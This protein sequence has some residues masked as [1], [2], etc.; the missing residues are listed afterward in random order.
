M[1][2]LT[3]KLFDRSISFTLGE[4]A[5]EFTAG[6]MPENRIYLPYRGVSRHHFTVVRDST[7]WLLRDEGS[8]NGTKLNGAKVTTAYLSTGDVI[9]AGT[10]ELR[11]FEEEGETPPFLIPDPTAVP[12]QART[13]RVD[14]Q[15]QTESLPDLFFFPKFVF[16]DGFLIGKSPAGLRVLQQLHSLIDGDV[17]ILFVG[18]TGTGKEMFARTM[19]LSAKRA[20]GPFVA[21]NCAAI[22]SELI[23]AELFG[24]GEKVATG[25]NR[26]IGKF[27]AADG[28]TLFLDELEACPAELQAKLLRAV[29]EKAYTPVGETAP[30][31]SNF[32]LISATNQNPKEL[33][34][35]RKFREDLY[36][37]LATF[38]I[39]LPALR[40]RTED[41]QD[42]ILQMLSRLAQ[43]Q[44]KHFAGVSHKFMGV[45]KKYSYPGNLR[46]LRNILRAVVA[47]AHSGE[48]LDVHLLPAKLLHPND[49]PETLHGIIQENLERESF[50]FHDV[51]S[52][53]SKQ[54]V[55]SV[56]D[57]HGGNVRKAAEQMKMSE[58]GLRKMMRRLGI[59]RT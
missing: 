26:R 42:L 25:V 5:S 2:I 28:G 19:H 33:V 56:L 14:Q 51:T 54:F 47:M 30:V 23:E 20:R 34:D 46:E 35:S 40:E 11:V 57:H 52:Q 44:A 53:V 48:I 17:N 43:E 39:R 1:F 13:D 18:E 49:P 10:I 9:Q 55:E 27:S 3:A 22:P 45:L 29:E 6:S 37:R 15:A 12:P 24:I 58:F 59:S 38:E 21:V 41:L 31:Q 50:D 7:G 36:H 4:D 32:R 8:T 16:P